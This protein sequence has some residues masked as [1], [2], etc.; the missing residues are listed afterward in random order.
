[1]RFLGLSIRTIPFIHQKQEVTS[2]YRDS[3]VSWKTLVFFALFPGKHHDMALFSIQPTRRV[4]S[5]STL[6][7][8]GCKFNNYNHFQTLGITERGAPTTLGR[9]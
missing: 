1:M 4:R 2:A 8:M 6:W 5:S 9:F 7:K 3:V